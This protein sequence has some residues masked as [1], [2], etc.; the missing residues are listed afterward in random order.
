MTVSS[1]ASRSDHTG[2]NSTTVFP[3]TFHIDANTDLLV[4]MRSTAGVESTS[5][6]TTDYTVS[7]V[8]NVAGGNV[9]FVTAPGTDVAITIRRVPPNTQTT[10]LRNQGRTYPESQETALDKVVKQ[11]QQLQDQVDRALQLMETEAG[12]AAKTTLPTV[13]DRASKFFSFDASGNP[14]ASS[15]I[16]GGTAATAFMQ[17]VLDDATAEAARSTL[18]IVTPRV[19]EARLSNSTGVAVPASDVTGATTMFL[20]PYGG[21]T[22]ALNDSS[23]TN[24]QYFNIGSQ[25]SISVPAVANQMY[26]VFVFNSGGTPTLEVVA[27]TNDTARATALAA[28]NG[29]YRKSGTETHRYVGSFRAD[30]ANQVSDSVLRRRVWNYYNRVKRRLIAVDST[31]N[32]DYTT[33]TWRQANAS[34][35]NQVDFVVGVL[36]EPLYMEVR[37]SARNTSAGVDIYA[38]IGLDSTSTNSASIAAYQQTQVANLNVTVSA[39]FDRYVAVGYHSLVWLEQSAATGTTTWN[40]DAGSS[41]LHTGIFGYIFA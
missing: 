41:D 3:Y 29:V 6:L 30:S 32:W 37:A 35:A 7:G 27:W 20:V 11:V 25:L 15:T 1:I 8:G 31:N 34:T 10:D 12:T 17:T 5:V 4:T 38:G 36:E 19:F 28:T 9:T 39:T 33:L 16:T 23:G 21:G 14:T 18:G 40:G 24:W 26:D 22:I 13:A 2:D